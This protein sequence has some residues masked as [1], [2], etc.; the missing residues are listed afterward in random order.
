VKRALLW[1]SL[2]AGCGPIPAA[3]YGEQLFNDS[4]FAGSQFNQWSC[5]T[6]HSVHSGDPRLLSGATLV[7]A[8]NRPSW[9]GGRSSRLIDAA[10][11]CYVY[12]MRGPQA[13]DPEEGRSR[14]L[15]EYLATL[16]KNADAP[17][18]P[19]TLTLNIVD[20]P[21]GDSARGET[22]YREAC[23][24]CHGAKDT[25]R[26]RN[27]P[28]A[29]ILPNVAAEYPTVFPGVPAGLVFIEKIR[30]GQFFEVGGNMPFFSKEA[31][32]DEDV[33][34]LLSYLGQ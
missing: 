4:Q 13:L 1:L 21:R 32:S 2:L 24:G 5:A 29:S 15:Y 31:L 22:V 30:H 7:D 12:F 23:L 17:A 19:M 34:A 14:A 27:S 20:V 3:S 10:S 16:G 6:C 25:G 28:L 11:F 9:F 18:L 26:G 33:G 8:V